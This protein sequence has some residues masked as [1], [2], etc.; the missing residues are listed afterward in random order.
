MLRV[1]SFLVV[2]TLLIAAVNP[3]AA[4]SLNGACS[5]SPITIGVN[6]DGDF[7]LAR[8]ANI[9]W[10]R[11]NLRWYQI[12]PAHGV[13][14]FTIADRIVGEAEARGL[15]ILG[16]LST[17]PQWA[18][19]GSLGNIPPSHTPYWEEYVRR[20][21]Q[22]Y[23]GRV[24]AYEIWNEPN[25]SG[26]SGIGIGWD[27]ALSVYP[28][29]TDYLRIAAQQ[30]RTW[31]PG[32]LVVG[33]G[34]SSQPNSRTVEIFKMIQS[35]NSSQ[36]IDVVSFHANGGDNSIIDVRSWIQSHL[37]TLTVRNPSNSAKPIWVT[38]M[39]WRSGA[40]GEVGQRD[41]VEDLVQELVADGG[42]LCQ[43]WT[44]YNFSHA[45]IFLLKD[46]GAETAGIYRATNVAK[47]VVS[48][49]IQPLGFPALAVNPTS[50]PP[51]TADCVGRICTFDAGEDSYGLNDYHWSFGDGSVTTGGPD[52]THT[53]GQPG[54]YF[55]KVLLQ[56]KGWQNG[57]SGGSMRLLWI[58]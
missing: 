23:K 26:N 39:G 46:V 41:R 9:G 36:Y 56:P 21:A 49:Y 18:G 38:E 34:T 11:V 29:Y 45:F 4:L 13:W 43:A 53:F 25:L 1:A 32:T 51:F 37:N 27:L 55:V 42:I 19:G 31:A 7:P 48:Q 28:R 40:V 5:S 44:V 15:R 35:T 57:G 14:D 22:R 3:V 6:A 10:V 16:I 54:W 2:S 12:N 47:P 50:V 24:A 20:V 8:N 58:G 52:V 33:P 30:I 17:A